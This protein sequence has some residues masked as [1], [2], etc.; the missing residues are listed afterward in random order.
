V[1]VQSWQLEGRTATYTVTLEDEVWSCTCPGC[2]Y[3]GRACR[4]IRA[5]QQLKTCQDEILAA[6]KNSPKKKAKKV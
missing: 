2:Q 1:A 3:H 4:H 5:M 6:L